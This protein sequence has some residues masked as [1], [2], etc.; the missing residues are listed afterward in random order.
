[1]YKGHINPNASPKNSLMLMR[2]LSGVFV[3]LSFVIARYKIAIIVTLM[4]L[5]WGAVAGSFMA[6]YF[7][8]LFW[9]KATRASIWAGLLTGLGLSISL[10]FILGPANSPIASSAAM[11]AP[12]IVIPVVS[13][14]TK[15]PDKELID[16]AFE[17]I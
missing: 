11:I 1:M 12:F 2:I 6:P 3:L 9:K 7:Y 14:F 17:N 4:S 15:S 8:G 10:F 16:K 13:S 5:S